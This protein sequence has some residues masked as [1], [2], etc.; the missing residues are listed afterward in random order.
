MESLN[1]VT[2]VSESKGKRVYVVIVENAE[3][4]AQEAFNWEFRAQRKHC[5][6]SQ[7]Q[8]ENFRTFLTTFKPHLHK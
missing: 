1:V 3:W 4:H 7:I 2:E 6:K 5:V 8:W